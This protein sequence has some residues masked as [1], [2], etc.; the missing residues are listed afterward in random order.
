MDSEFRHSLMNSEVIITTTVAYA[1]CVNLNFVHWRG[2]WLVLL[3]I[4]YENI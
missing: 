3:Y 4:R 2:A 1:L